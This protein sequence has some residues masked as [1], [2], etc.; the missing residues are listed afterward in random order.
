MRGAGTL[1]F[2]NIQPANDST[3]AS[4]V[5]TYDAVNSHKS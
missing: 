5:L 4:I 2:D 1:R 3:A